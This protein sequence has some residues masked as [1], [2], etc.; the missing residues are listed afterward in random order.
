MMNNTTVYATYNVKRNG[1]HIAEVEF[2][3]NTSCAN[4][5]SV[6]F[7]D[8]ITNTFLGTTEVSVDGTT[9]TLERVA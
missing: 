2:P 1:K 7:Y 3:N 5:G 8:P 4:F 6:C 9:F